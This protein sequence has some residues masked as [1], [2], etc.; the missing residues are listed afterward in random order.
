MR[1]IIVFSFVICIAF[2]SK[3]QKIFTKTAN[4]TFN[5]SSPLEPIEGTTRT[6][7]TVVDLSNGNMEFAVLVKSFIFPQALM[8][9]HFNENYMESNK[10][11]KAIFKGKID[12]LKEINLSKDGS[13]KAKVSGNLEMHGIT[14]PVA[15]VADFVVKGGKIKATSNFAVTIADYGI[16]IPAAV[17]DKIAK[18]AKINII[19]EYMPLNK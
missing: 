4:V 11:P 10:F 2:A 3:A 13:Y 5:A 19:A 12:N 16:S 18:T 15:T 7:T 6:A 9:E 14:K 1:K 8:Q 17:K